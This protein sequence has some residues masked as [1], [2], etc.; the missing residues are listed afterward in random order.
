VLIFSND[1]FDETST[2]TW[3]VENA[4]NGP[5]LNVVLCGGTSLADLD[6]EGAVVIPSF[7]KGSKERLGFIAQRC[8]LVAKY[9][10]IH[11]AKYTSTCFDNTN[12]LFERDNYPRLQAKRALFQIRATDKHVSNDAPG[13]TRAGE[14]AS[15]TPSVARLTSKAPE[16]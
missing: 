14:V 10:D 4:G 15:A 11:G 1:A 2:T 16:A 3:C 12:R 9:S 13:A 5:A 6:L 8:A 7:A